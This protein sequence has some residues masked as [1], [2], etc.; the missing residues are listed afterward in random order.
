MPSQAQN[1]RFVEYSGYTND[2]AY[3]TGIPQTAPVAGFYQNL[4]RT[5][6][7]DLGFQNI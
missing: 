5:K 2:P 7:L 4:V 1:P 3:P 6:L